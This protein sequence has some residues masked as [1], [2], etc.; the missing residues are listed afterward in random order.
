MSLASVAALMAKMGAAWRGTYAVMALCMVTSV[1]MAQRQK[2]SFTLA[3]SIAAHDTLRFDAKDLIVAPQGDYVAWIE[4]N[5]LYAASAP[6][7]EPKRRAVSASGALTAVYA[8]TDGRTLFYTL[9]ESLPAFGS[10]AAEDR[11]EFWRVDARQGEPQ[12]LAQGADVPAGVPVFAPDGQRFVTAEGTML[13]EYRVAAQ[14]LE[15]R[16]LLQRDAEHYAAVKLSSLI[17]SPDG[18]RLAFVSWRKAKQSYIGIYDFATGA[19]RYI[20]PGIFR[21]LSPVWSPDSKELAFVRTAS[22]WTRGYR[23]S[24]TIDGAPWR[25]LIANAAEGTVRTVW[26]AELGAGSVFRPFGIG[27]WM[28]PDI[29]ASQLFW[30]RAGHLVFPWEKSGWLALYSVSSQGGE[31]RALTTGE[32]EVATPTLSPDGSH[33]LYASN[34]GDL[35]RLHLWRVALDAV[36]PPEQ[37]TSGKGVEHSPK[38][39]AS[40]GY[41]YI[42]NLA[43]RMPNRRMI[44]RTERSANQARVLTPSAEETTRDQKIWSQFVDAEVLP[45][46]AEDGVMSHHLL[47]VPKQAPPKRGFPVIISSKGGPNGRVSPGNALYSALGQY[48]VSRGYIF[49]EINY[50]GCDGFGLNYRLPAGRGATGGSEVKDLAALAKYLA[51]RADVDARRMGIMG[52]SYGG[53]IVG[54]ALTQLP[55]YF[56]AGAHLSGVADWNVEMQKDQQE[57]Q[58][59][60]AGASAPPPYIRLSERMQ[61]EDLAFASSS[62]ARIQAWRA[63]TFISMGELDTSGHMEAIIDLG[64]R[65]L[66]Q[67]THVEF[68]IAPEAG[69]FGPR[70]RPV[71]KVFEFFERTLR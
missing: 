39:T 9:G 69:H 28:Q 38:F 15:K 53:H 22:N 60:G 34:V 24:P 70:A 11:R 27:A 29:E 49:V 26:Q 2:E 63:P 68:A 17:Y 33:L 52:G 54:L 32:G 48:A 30:T 59:S 57:E 31:A 21:D 64:Y 6:G 20:D 8:S 56:A 13:Y 18:R 37:L 58:E 51:G 3:E 4:G 43:G 12:R 25:L 19:H 55:Q 62:I 46:R 47:M 14:G 35:A 50:R 61:I 1:S 7:F 67:G 23:F 5:V 41:A 66:E 45:L 10:Y 16:A 65:L 71:D 40:G 44:V 42:A 36:T